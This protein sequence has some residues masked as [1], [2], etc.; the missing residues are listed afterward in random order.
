MISEICRKMWCF[1]PQ[2]LQLVSCR[3]GAEPYLL[4]SVSSPLMLIFYFSIQR[5]L[6]SDILN[7]SHSTNLSFSLSLLPSL[8]PPFFLAV[9][10][11]K[12]RALCM[13]AKCS[14][15]KLHPQPFLC[16]LWGSSIHL[17]VHSVNHSNR[18]L[19]RTQKIQSDFHIK[20][21]EITS[22][23]WK[24]RTSRRPKTS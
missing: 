12:H 11:I 5:F 2:N 17:L 16:L 8:P 4:T 9:L 20:E 3:L 19:G 18:T 21:T 14:P 24:R 23:S 15:T 7:E 10:G 22:F 13:L 6:L 1:S